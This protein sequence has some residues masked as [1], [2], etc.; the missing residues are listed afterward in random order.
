MK[1]FLRIVVFIFIFCPIISTASLLEAK[2]ALKNVIVISV[3]TLRADHLGCY[4]YP[5]ATSPNIDALARDGV[6]FANGFTLTPLTAPSFS[7]MLTSLPPHQHGAKRN[8]LSIYKKIKTIPYFLK[9]YGYRSA[10]FISNWPLRKK[11][12]GLHHHFDSYHEVFTKKRYMGIMQNEGNAPTVT[13]KVIAWLEENNKKRFFL[14][15]QYTEPHFPYIMHD[16][17]SFNYNNLPSD[18]YPAG[19]KMSKIKKYD[20][21][22]AYTDFYI[23]QLITKLKELN[24]YEDAIIVFHADHGESFGE[25]NYFRHG[26]KLYN[27]TLHV[28]MIFKLP[29]GSN[30]STIRGEN[31]SIMDIGPT[32]FSCLQIL[33][34]SQMKGIPLMEPGA[35]KPNREILLETYGGAVHFRRSSQKYHLKIK[36]IRYAYL[37]GPYKVIYNLKDKTVEAY[38]LRRDCFETRN[39]YIDGPLRLKEIKKDLVNKAALVMKYIQLNKSRYLESDG[40]SPDD[41]RRLKSLGYVYEKE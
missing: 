31:V 30:K 21:E 15:V 5:L 28:P 4:G 16:E 34:H 25:H 41:L 20:S 38:E 36:P 29:G 23:G 37:S 7:T 32:I 26:R 14:W 35:V 3:D 9:R 18:T 19:T 8:G 13:E 10:A 22:I 12:G 33:T 24:L 40:L 2:P 39:I 11:L 17:F 27:S 6:L 1:N